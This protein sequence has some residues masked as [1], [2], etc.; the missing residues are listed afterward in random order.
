MAAPAARFQGHCSH[1]VADVERA[2]AFYR[3]AFGGEPASA[4]VPISAGI[5]R[6]L[7]GFPDTT[8]RVVMVRFEGCAVELLELTGDAAP[9]LPRPTGV[10]PHFALCVDDIEAAFA[11]VEPAGGTILCPVTAPSSS[12]ALFFCADPDDQPIEVMTYT[13][14]DSIARMTSVAAAA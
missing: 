14:E 5:V 12:G 7:F 11:A 10:W 2:V 4:P 1:R 3:D 9:P 6:S 13:V 8:A